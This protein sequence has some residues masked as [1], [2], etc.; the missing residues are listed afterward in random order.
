MPVENS[1]RVALAPCPAPPLSSQLRAVDPSSAFASA[2]SPLDAALARV[3]ALLG[4][5]GLD[6]CADVTI[7]RGERER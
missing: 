2:P 4:R 5:L 3:E 7:V 6:I 1:K